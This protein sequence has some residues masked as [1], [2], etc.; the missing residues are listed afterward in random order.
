MRAKTPAR[1]QTPRFC[2]RASDFELRLIREAATAKG[3][4][5]S[6]IVRD[7]LHAAGVLDLA[8]PAAVSQEPAPLP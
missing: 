5:A 1:A 2:F 7:A 4:T 8:D 3:V 6:E